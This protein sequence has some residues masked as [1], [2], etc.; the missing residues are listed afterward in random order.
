MQLNG[1]R[2]VQMTKYLV[3]GVTIFCA[4]WMVC[5]SEWRAA[6]AWGGRAWGRRA[7]APPPTMRTIVAYSEEAPAG[8]RPCPVACDRLPELPD[9]PAANWSWSRERGAPP[10][11]QAVRGASTLLYRAYY[12]DRFPV[13]YVRI[14]A[15]FP[16]RRFPEEVKLYCRTHRKSS[17]NTKDITSIEVVTAE[18]REIWYST[19]DL[20]SNYIET[21]LLLSCPLTD[22]L[23]GP[24]TVSIVTETCEDASNAFIIQP[25]ENKGY[26]RKFTVCVKDLLFEKDISR[27]LVEWIEANRVLGVEKIDVYVDKVSKAT[28]NILE[29][30]RSTGF[31]RLYNV[32]IN[33][34]SQQNINTLW[35]RRRDHLISLNDCLYRNLKESEFIIPL[36]IDEIILPKIADNLLGLTRRLINSG[37]N[38]SQESALVQNVFF[39]DHIQNS[40]KK[41]LKTNASELYLK[42]DS[43]RLRDNSVDIASNEILYDSDYVFSEKYRARCGE[44][45]LIP[46][47]LRHTRRSPHVGLYEHPKSLMVTRLVLLAFNHYPLASRVGPLVRPM[48]WLAPF[49]EVQLNHYKASCNSALVSCD[50]YL[51]NT[52]PDRNA[53]RLRRRVLRALSAAPCLA[54]DGIN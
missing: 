11:W 50:K 46:K 52:Q 43:V 41:N 33:H 16:G 22:P 30:Y 35:Q 28:E 47:L 25:N 14:L 29:H 9:V 44:D 24:S 15:K 12:D 4:S 32:P 42:R 36:D 21:P 51:R 19:W 38:T 31:L 40:D 54:H 7:R 1:R 37:W 26:E 17:D 20:G 53:L 3:C 27:D 39:F 10:A 13:P 2:V 34:S 48:H 8:E 49:S 6:G 18:T 5:V 45:L 23:D